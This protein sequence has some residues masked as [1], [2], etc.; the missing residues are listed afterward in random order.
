MA[1]MVPSSPL[2]PCKAT[3]TTSTPASV[4]ACSA[5]VC[6]ARISASSSEAGGASLTRELRKRTSSSPVSRP[7]DVSMA[8]TSCPDSRNARTIC[9]P[10][11][12]DTS[13]SSLVPPNSTAI[14]SGLVCIA[15]G[16]QFVGVSRGAREGILLRHNR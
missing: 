11:A 10:L 5:L 1:C 12:I 4:A 13:R 9:A 3:N 15:T 6:P 16:L 8:S 7:R 2:P 14:L